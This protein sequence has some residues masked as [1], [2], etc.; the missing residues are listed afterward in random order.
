MYKIVIY[1]NKFTPFKDPHTFE[2][3][4]GPFR[5]PFEASVDDIIAGIMPPYSLEQLYVV[6]HDSR[7]M[8]ITKERLE[9]LKDGSIFNVSIN[10]TKD[11]DTTTPPPTE[12]GEKKSEQGD[13]ETKK[14][15]DDQTVIVEE[16]QE[17][18]QV[19]SDQTEDE[20]SPVVPPVMTTEH[21]PEYTPGTELEPVKTEV[22]IT[23]KSEDGETSDEQVAEV[24]NVEDNQTT[25]TPVNVTEEST[26]TEDETEN[27]D[28]VK[29]QSSPKHKKRNNKNSNKKLNV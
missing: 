11:D 16:T 20:T 12:S 1:D 3:L 14:T 19:S 8:L 2:D 27:T 6:S 4:C 23:D 10:N 5:S 21:N 25:E 24:I 17:S 9:S 22:K 13:L 29:T 28:K 7:E 26:T 18:S 15:E